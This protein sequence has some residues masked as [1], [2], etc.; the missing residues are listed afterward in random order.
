MTEA[1]SPG[2]NRAGRCELVDEL[3]REPELMDFA[4]GAALAHPPRDDLGVLHPDIED[5]DL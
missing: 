5:E 1:G 2:E 4:E 3:V